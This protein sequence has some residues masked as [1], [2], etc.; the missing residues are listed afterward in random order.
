M[1][2]SISN[3]PNLISPQSLGLLGKSVW[4]PSLIIDHLKNALLKF[5]AL[6]HIPLAFAF[7]DS[8]FLIAWHFCLCGCWTANPKPDGYNDRE[9][10]GC[11]G[12]YQWGRHDLYCAL[13]WGADETVWALHRWRYLLLLSSQDRS[14][15]VVLSERM[16]PLI[17][18][19][20]RN[21]IEL[22]QW[23]WHSFTEKRA[24]SRFA[25]KLCQCYWFLEDQNS[26]C[27]DER[28][29]T[30]CSHDYATIGGNVEYQIL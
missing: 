3:S 27:R 2:L 18:L 26:E 28:D 9:D 29:L 10:G 15:S 21:H 13:H 17:I 4:L 12:W 19:F 7:L 20:S 30:F 1:D 8:W 5:F 24:N 14:V 16:S 22:L 6:I 25:C 11:S 23:F